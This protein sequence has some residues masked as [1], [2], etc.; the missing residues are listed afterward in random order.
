MNVLFRLD[1]SSKIGLG[2]LM[3]CLTLADELNLLRITCSFVIN[4]YDLDLKSMLDSQGMAYEFID[5]EANAVTY[6]GLQVKKQPLLVIVDNYQLGYQWQRLVKDCGASIM[7]IDDLANR[8]FEVD[9]LLDQNLVENYQSRYQGLLLGSS[10]VFLGAEYALLRRE[11]FDARQQF[12]AFE[13]RLNELQVLINFGGSDPDNETLKALKGVLAAK[14]IANV[15]VIIG[16]A[17]QHLEELNLWAAKYSRVMI[18]QNVKNMA[19][20]MNKA[21]IMVGAVGTTAWERCSLGVIGL[22]SSIADNQLA[23]ARYLHKLEAHYYL[24]HHSDLAPINYQRGLEG[25]LSSPSLMR[26]I[27]ENSLALVDGQGAQR[28]ARHIKKFITEKHVTS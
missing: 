9:L 8:P 11:F 19:Y 1:A 20:Y 5:D 25:I 16:G 23:T 6:I 18:L 24:G 12:L 4:Q 17:Y 21:L 2:H 13:N 28:I 10:T 22:V 26:S 14:H 15:T 3:R 7:A 27:H